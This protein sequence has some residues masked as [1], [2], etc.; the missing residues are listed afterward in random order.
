ITV[1]I[2]IAVYP[3][4]GTNPQDLLKKSDQALYA[5][6]EAGRNRVCIAEFNHQK[7]PTEN[8]KKKVDKPEG[9]PDKDKLG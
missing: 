2:G 3:D 6:K 5:A 1:S 4:H 8:T 7:E 9:I